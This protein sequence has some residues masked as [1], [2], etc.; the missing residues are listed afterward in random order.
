MRVMNQ[1]SIKYHHIKWIY[2]L[3][4]RGQAVSRVQLAQM[5]GLSKTT[6]SALV[7]ELIQNGYLIEKGTDNA[8]SPGRKAHLLRINGEGNLVAVVAWHRH[9]LCGALI[10]AQ[11]R[12]VMRCEAA[13]PENGDY[14]E[15]TVRLLKEN[16]LL[17]AKHSR[18]LGVCVVVPSMVDD[19]KQQIISTVLGLEEG[20]DAV[21]RLRKALPGYPMAILN[22][23][24]CYA[25]AEYMLGDIAED[26]YIFVNIGKGVGAVLLS[27]GVM[28]RG[29]NGMTT[30]F[31]HSSVDRNGPLCSCGNRGC[32]ERMIGEGALPELVEKFGLQ[33]AFAGVRKIRFRD[34]GALTAAND[35]RALALA[36]HLAEDLAYGLSNLITLF[37][38]QLVV[39]GGYGMHM[40]EAFL[41]FVNQR[42]KHMGFPQFVQDTR[43]RFARVDEHAELSGAAGYYLDRHF[44]FDGSMNDKLILT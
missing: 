13:M 14:V 12:T 34:L 3:V 24:A 29:A 32:L 9:E 1:H 4:S 36:E 39:I 35:E 27:K 41:A 2:T 5:T 19:R 37:N 8:S 6:V 11:N 40:G 15:E 22:D 7:E 18:V 38:P 44:V 21:Q 31:G 28:L 20:N 26:E 16:L 43:L 42:L 33:E 17:Q 23:T 10:D 30:Q 25:Y